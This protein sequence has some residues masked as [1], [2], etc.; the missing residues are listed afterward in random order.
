MPKSTH[1][2]QPEAIQADVGETTAYLERVAKMPLLQTVAARSLEALRLSAGHRVLD[3]GCGS[4]VFLPHLAD[5][6][7]PT[8]HVVGVDRASALVQVARSR[9]ADLGTVTVEEADAYQL[10]FS[11]NTFDA[12]HC[13]RVLMHLE[14]PR[15]AL[16][17]MRRVVKKGGWIVVAEPDWG[18]LQIASSDPTAVALL[19]TSW[20]R[21]LAQ[22]RMGLELYS[23]FAE[24]GL[25]D[26]SVTPVVPG[27]I[28]YQELLAYGLDL[29]GVAGALDAAGVLNQVRSRA[30]LD[31]WASATAEGRFF[32]YI[33]MFVMAARVPESH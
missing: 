5:I 32:G 33:C 29:D 14:H 21:G 10:P 31:Q 19:L 30:V 23:Q 12:A 1:D 9:A 26:L 24:V 6:V 28:D 11:D 18:G 22:P 27:V 25:T 2:W 7:G 15:R 8:G 4:G 16:R 20:L 13:E 17:E 3:V